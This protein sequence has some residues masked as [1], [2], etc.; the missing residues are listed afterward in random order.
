MASEYKTRYFNTIEEVEFFGYLRKISKDNTKLKAEYDYWYELPDA[1]KHFFVQP[2]G[3]YLDGEVAYYY[4]EHY[5][6]K[7]AAEQM[8]F[9][10]LSDAAFIRLMRKISD[11]RKVLPDEPALDSQVDDNARLLVLEKTRQRI[12]EL[13]NTAWFKSKYALALESAGITPEI[14]YK[15]L[16]EKFNEHYKRRTLKRIVCSHGDLVFSN[17]LYDD[18]IGIMKLVD[19]KGRDFMFMDEYYDLAKLSQSINGNYED[20][21]YGEY[22][23]NLD[24]KK[25]FIK[26][27]ENQ[28]HRAEFKQ[29]LMQ[30]NVDLKLLRTYEA[31]L[32]LSM[33]PLHIDDL[34]RVAAL[35]VNCNKILKSI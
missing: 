32:F 11:F 13:N 31:S 34:E 14:L 3:F 24:S 20:I 15:E 27:P 4:M 16:E 18:R 6:I 33:L 25:L 5:K 23:L 1:I 19:P 7:N 17:I 12:E 8:V 30:Q 35:L 10:E 26:R 22:S 28:T 9:G 2:F 21:I 29:Y